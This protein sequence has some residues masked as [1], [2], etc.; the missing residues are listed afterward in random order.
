MR[1]ADG[2]RARPGPS[3]TRYV[4]ENVNSLTKSEPPPP[5][6]SH[7]GRRLSHT[8][9]ERTPAIGARCGRAGRSVASADM[10]VLT[11]IIVRRNRRTSPARARRRFAA[12]V[13][14]AA[15]AAAAPVAGAQAAL[16]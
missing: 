3:P 11:W 15:L 14:A 5:D 12:A 9:V 1:G 10:T 2:D 16:A 6:G 13:A 4:T 8:G 7:R